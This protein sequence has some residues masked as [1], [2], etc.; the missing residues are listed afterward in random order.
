MH[1]TVL[2]VL[3]EEGGGGEGLILHFAYPTDGGP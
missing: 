3:N 2:E 1:K